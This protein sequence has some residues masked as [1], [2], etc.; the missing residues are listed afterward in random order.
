[1]EKFSLNL[2]V[3]IPN[4]SGD[5][6]GCIQRI[7]TRLEEI[8]GIY[9][10][11]AKT[12]DGNVQLCL[13]YDPTLV[14]LASLKR[15]VNNAGAKISEQYQHELLTILGMDCSDCVLSIEHTLKRIDGVI[16]ATV[17][18]AAAILRIEYDTTQVSKNE[19]V[20]AIKGLGYDVPK[21]G[22]SAFLEQKR[23]LI[24]VLAAGVFLLLGVLSN[25]SYPAISLCF[26][27]LS[28]LMGG[29]DIARHAL[30]A[31]LQ[32]HFDTDLLMIAAALGAAF[33]G[34]YFEGA[35]LLF[36]FSLGHVLE[37]IALDKARNAVRE[38]GKLT[39]KT[40][41]VRR[42]QKEEEISVDD[43][44]IGDVVM[45][46]PGARIPA[47]GIVISGNSFV[48]QAS[49]T[50]ESVPIEKKNRDNVFAGTVNGEGA[51]EVQV[52]KL[53]KDNTL[54][55]VLQI[56]E[57]AQSQKTNSEK[58]TEAFTKKFVPIVLVGDVIFVIVQ[59]L[60]SIPFNTAFLRAMT[61]LV[62]ASPCALA[63]GTPSAMLCGI[64]RAASKGVLVKGGIH[65][66]TLGKVDVIAFDKTGTL[67]LGKPEIQDILMAEKEFQE[68]SIILLAASAEDKS[69]HPLALAFKQLA[70]NR[71]LQLQEV[72]EVKSITGKGLQAS[73]GE[74][75]VLLGNMKLMEVQKIEVPMEIKDKAVDFAA[76]GKTLVFMS[77]DEKFA[78]L[79][80][81]ADTPR[82]D[83][84]PSLIELKKL[85]IK[86]TVLLTGD[87]E[88]VGLS[89]AKRLGLD[90]V[91]ADLMPQDKVTELKKLAQNRVIAMVG[92][93][94]N[95]APALAAA[96]VG[97][98]MGGA[99]TDVALETADIALMNDDLSKLPYAISLGRETLQVVKQNIFISSAVILLLLLASAFGVA[100]I[101]I[102]VVI[103]EG[104]TLVVVANS[105]RLLRH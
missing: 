89:M 83:A 51:I 14:T 101:A 58:I 71:S 68:E 103:H 53:T 99:S 7:K 38:L 73:V 80:T 66:E 23:E 47:D 60:F 9:E 1:M 79:F 67:T 88:K 62:A 35:L 69:G 76:Q 75:S 98:A 39:P 57:E 22:I 64:A 59:L 96:N 95:D 25:Q 30:S 29:F 36:L 48:D 2:D 4:L 54:S 28:Y 100:S 81:L 45:V 21:S 85:G 8:T 34:E 15:F 78:A 87:N 40:A 65:L 70:Q 6:D 86:E 27:A 49:I 74:K 5:E 43:L 82:T 56:V 50:G 10:V 46:K 24:C 55:K 19:I 104:S 16:S 31:L 77:V 102:A 84:K 97:I 12:Q 61:V 105:L 33:L 72:R 94:V 42:A 93:G 92:D 20:K 26:Y 91:K 32:K 44:Q 18:Y 90:S 3:L 11:H 13:H 17:N 41:T 37:E 52:S 63:L